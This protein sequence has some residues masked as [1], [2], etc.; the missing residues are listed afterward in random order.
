MFYKLESEQLQVKAT[1]KGAELTSIKCKKT[2]TEYLWQGSKSS[3]DEQAPI[4][5]PS[6]GRMK[7][8][9][10]TYK[11][12][13]YDMGL[14]GFARFLEFTVKEEPNKLVFSL[15]DTPETR[16]NYP[17]A[18]LLEIIYTLNG[19]NL[20]TEYRVTNPGDSNQELIFGIGAHPGFNCPLVSGTEFTD[21]YLE[22]EGHDV[23][24]NCSVSKNGR[25]LEET[26]PINL[27]NSSVPISI[28]LFKKYPTVLLVDT[29]V[30]K[31][32]IKSEKT[33]KYVSMTFDA[34]HLA[35]WSAVPAPFV[36]LEPWD[37][38]PDFE[39]TD[40]DFVTKKGNH[41]LPPGGVKTF[42]HDVTF[43]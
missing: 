43:G 35:I 9:K 14:H 17:F 38:L 11:G 7:D 15:T 1:T 12:K 23:L 13:T 10:Y 25:L 8:F 2:G 3:W 4:L 32:A 36:C 41:I 39:E 21:Y 20:K 19:S 26:T 40:G 29:P 22:F 16:E 6:V 31:V 24:S 30:K 5:F 37:G 34:Q 42:C 28:D 33:D 18:F 27:T